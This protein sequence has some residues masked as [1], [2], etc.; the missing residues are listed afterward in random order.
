MKN[1]RIPV[2][3]ENASINITDIGDFEYV[4]PIKQMREVFLNHH[5]NVIGSVAKMKFQNVDD[6]DGKLKS[7]IFRLATKEANDDL[8]EFIED[9][10]AKKFP[11]S[12]M[13]LLDSHKKSRQEKAFRGPVLTSRELMAFIFAAHEER[14]FKY[15]MYSTRGTGVGFYQA[16]MPRF[17]M[18][19]EN[20]E[21][22][23]VGDTDLTRGEIKNAIDQQ[24]DNYA[25]FLDKGEKWHCFFYTND[26]INGREN[27]ALP[28]IHYISHLWNLSRAEVLRQLKSKPYKLPPT[29]HIP[30]ERYSSN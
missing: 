3:G 19:Q 23:I 8:Q 4:N 11:H 26:G 27:G 12:F 25:R 9:A 24:N 29:P 18:K 21:L 22:L 30:F 15:S 13:S 5:L 2:P 14:G 6:S 7:T 17:A 1:L 20:G 10:K 28:H 16:R